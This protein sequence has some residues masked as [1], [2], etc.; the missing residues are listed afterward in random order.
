MAKKIL[1][2]QLS[3]E[4]GSTKF[5][6][7]Q[8]AE[9]RLGSD[10]GRNDISL[11]ENLG[12]SPE[13]AR[14]VKQQDDT[15]IVAPVDRTSQVFVHRKDGRAPKQITAP[16]ALTDGDGFSLV[17][18]E[19]PK[20]IIVLEHPKQAAAAD[21]G[22]AKA[23]LGKAASRLSAKSLMGEIKRIGFAKAITSSVGGSLYKAFTF[24]KSGAFLQPRYI[25]LG[26]FL[27]S[28]YIFAGTMSCG[29][30][31]LGLS[32]ANTQ[33]EL[34]NVK[35]Q[36]NIDDSGEKQEITLNT[37][38]QKLLGKAGAGKEIKSLME[39][40]P[41]FT[42]LFKQHLLNI[43]QKAGD[44]EWIKDTGST[45]ILNTWQKTLA[46]SSAYD[47]PLVR[48]FTY[49]AAPAGDSS[50]IDKYRIGFTPTDEKLTCYRGP[51]QISWRQA[52]RFQFSNVF[53]DIPVD[54]EIAAQGSRDA[55]EPLLE[56]YSGRI[57]ADNKVD[58]VDGDVITVDNNQQ[59]EN[60]K[61]CV[62]VE[63]EDDRDSDISTLP[64]NLK[65]ILGKSAPGVPGSGTGNY[66]LN[67]AIRWYAADL[68]SGFS[69]MDKALKDTKLTLDSQIKG[70]SSMS[71]EGKEYVM[72]K[73]A[74]LYAKAAI[75]PCL[76]VMAN[77]KPPDW[78]KK[79]AL[80]EE[81][82]IQCAIFLFLIDEAASK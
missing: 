78:M 73:V 49:L 31:G 33:E 21:A 43:K 58:L 55:L 5:G 27:L 30:A 51:L 10:P 25:I 70:N 81:S 17:A 62:Y 32:L 39:K 61:Q 60:T 74:E 20:F 44:Y 48:V 26:M 72:D 37:E 12:V 68:E 41:E 53:L 29:A 13:H 8:G 67:R 1:F 50:S 14:L 38:V 36:C 71:P 23:G 77:D 15:F 66:T 22:G 24:I 34:T 3:A 63:G 47:E 59:M 11:P 6:P 82:K 52:K 28:G 35:D 69:D 16:L 80:A 2:L 18:A 54:V 64:A 56:A 7:F 42:K 9:V 45:N 79:D 76:G 46:K 40:D 4:F 65:K 57:G 19:G 75:L